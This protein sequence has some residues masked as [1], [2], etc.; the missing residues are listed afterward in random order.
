MI[1]HLNNDFVPALNENHENISW[2][3]LSMLY[4][5]KV[6]IYGE[7]K[8]QKNMAKWH[9]SPNDSKLLYSK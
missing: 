9:T 3:K 8:P 5:W 2:L 4:L 6:G 1:F 7:N